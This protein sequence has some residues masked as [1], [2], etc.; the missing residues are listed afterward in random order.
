MGNFI[1]KQDI[2]PHSVNNTVYNVS[3]PDIKEIIEKYEY[4]K[5]NK[6]ITNKNKI[7]N[8]IGN[9]DWDKI[10]YKNFEP[11]A[12]PIINAYDQPS[13]PPIIAYAQPIFEPGLYDK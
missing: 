1:K 4:I 12:P 10:H 7:A 11:S 6:N 2:S 3:P 9:T 5:H 13:A 8:I